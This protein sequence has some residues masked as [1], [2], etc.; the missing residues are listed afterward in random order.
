MI[1]SEELKRPVDNIPQGEK[2][3][4]KIETL[5]DELRQLCKNAKQDAKLLYEKMKQRPLVYLIIIIVLMI[6]SLSLIAIPHWQLSKYQINNDINKAD[7]ENQYR[8][9]LAQILGGVAILFTLYFAWGNLTTARDGQVAERFT[10]AVDQ[11]G[12]T[13]S[14]KKIME[15][16]LGG[17]YALERIANQFDKYYYWQIMEILT[18]YIRTNYPSDIEITEEGK[19][20]TPKKGT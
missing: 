6:A 13:Q 15:I 11:L 12:S 20:Y 16:R 19:C 5:K 10:K 1:L 3:R 4:K 17:I 8:A 2:Q 14:D 18:A 7:L 9:T